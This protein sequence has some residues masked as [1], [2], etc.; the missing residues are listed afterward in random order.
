MHARKSGRAVPFFI[1]H[2][3]PSALKDTRP[4]GRVARGEGIIPNTFS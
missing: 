3:N 4:T 2:P 1:L